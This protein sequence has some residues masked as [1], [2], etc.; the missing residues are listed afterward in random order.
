MLVSARFVADG[1][2]VTLSG[3]CGVQDRQVRMHFHA[4][5]EQGGSW[6]GSADL[7]MESPARMTGRIQSKRGDDVGIVLKK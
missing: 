6:D 1:T 2:H 4:T 7:T 5:T 3:T